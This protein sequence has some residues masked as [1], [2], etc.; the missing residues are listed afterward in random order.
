MIVVSHDRY[1]LNQVV[2]LLLVLDGRGGVKVIHGNYD[3][4]EMMDQEV[5]D[6]KAAGRAGEGGEGGGEGG[7]A[8]GP[9]AAAPDKGKRKRKHPYR[10]VE[11]IEAT[12]R[13]RRRVAELGLRWRR[14]N[15]TR[16]ARRS[17]RR[18]EFEGVKAKVAGLYEQWEEAVELDR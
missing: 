1:F 11:D 2:D 3:T 4:Y 8:R 17:R 10:R 16:T 7:G 6:A 9:P 5:A 13:R 18:R 15:C 12:W 14:R